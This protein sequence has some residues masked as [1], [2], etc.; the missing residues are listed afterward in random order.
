MP[1]RPGVDIGDRCLIEGVQPDHLPPVPSDPRRCRPCAY[2]RTLPNGRNP[3]YGQAWRLH[4]VSPKDGRQRQP[5]LSPIP[6]QTVPTPNLGCT[7]LNKPTKRRQIRVILS[8]AGTPVICGV[9]NCVESVVSEQPNVG[10]PLVGAHGRIQMPLE[11]SSDCL[12]P[13]NP[14]RLTTEYPKAKVHRRK[15]LNFASI[16][17]HCPSRYREG[18]DC[19]ISIE[20]QRKKKTLRRS[21]S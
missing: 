16:L 3:P 9:H 18:D 19:K 12:G 7:P 4:Y 6:R 5:P 1:H 21:T 15:S 14:L 17:C 2:P 10:S 20:S 13:E 8:V 11:S